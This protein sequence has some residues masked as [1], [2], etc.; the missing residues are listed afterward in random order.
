MTTSMSADIRV[1]ALLPH[2]G[3]CATKSLIGE[4][5]AA[6]SAAG[7]ASL[8]A[9]DHLSYGPHGMEDPDPTFLETF[10]TLAYAAAHGPDLDLGTAAVIPIRHPLILAKTAAS[11]AALT[12]GTLRLGIGAGFR[13][14]EFE[15]VGL[16]AKLR[17]RA[18]EVIPRTFDILRDLRSG[19]SLEGR[20]SEY[21]D[22]AQ[23]EQWPA[24]PKRTRF[25]YCG[26]SPRS[27]RLSAEYADGWAPGRITVPTMHRRLADQT[28]DLDVVVIP[29]VVVAESKAEAAAMLDL[30]SLL[31]YANGHRWLEKPASG[32]FATAD[33]LEGIVLHGTPDD[34]AV[35]VERLTA[36]GATDV[37][38]D[39]RLGWN[40]APEIISE[41]GSVLGLTRRGTDMR[42]THARA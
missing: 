37:V 15:I 41:L 22:F 42:G 10:T 11:L 14:R 6:A 30:D 19:G 7:L 24:L 1:G 31:E 20:H 33:D 3:S 5:S 21:W 25:L 18:N 32:Q 34:I 16:N 39:L 38:L 28:G 9:R 40:R 17:E 2:F 12:D 27:V 4:V 29:L 36:A 35:G 13:D 26:T 23:T 8:W